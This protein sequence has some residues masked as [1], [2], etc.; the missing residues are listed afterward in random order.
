MKILLDILEE[1]RTLVDQIKGL[2]RRIE[3]LD[4][5][6]NR[7]PEW[8]DLVTDVENEVVELE[9][10]Q[11]SLEKTRREIVSYLDNIKGADPKWEDD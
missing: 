5:L 8:T 1:E 10:L 7:Y 6:I 9:K 11:Q 2:N 3:V 4:Q